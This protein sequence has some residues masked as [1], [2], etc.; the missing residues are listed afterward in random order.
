MIVSSTSQSD[1]R[2]FVAAPEGLRLDV[3]QLEEAASRATIALGVDIGALLAVPSPDLAPD[4]RRTWPRR[5]GFFDGGGFLAP[6]SFI[7]DVAV[8]TC[9]R[10]FRSAAAPGSGWPRPEERSDSSPV[11]ESPGW[12]F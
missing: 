4:R 9:F 10:A 12:T 2:C 1:I 8:G 3:V 6:G 7:A 11:S 5:A